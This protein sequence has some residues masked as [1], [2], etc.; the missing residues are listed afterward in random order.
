MPL[1]TFYNEETY[2]QQ[3]IKKV[4]SKENTLIFS[5]TLL[6]LS[7]PRGVYLRVL[8]DI[9]LIFF[10]YFSWCI[11][12]RINSVFLFSF[13]KTF[14][15]LLFV[16]KGTYCRFERR[17]RGRKVVSSA[18][19]FRRFYTAFCI[20]VYVSC[21]TLTT[22]WTNLIL[23]MLSVFVMKKVTDNISFLVIRWF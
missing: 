1:A 20:T 4:F 18:A 9:I 7:S 13:S 5:P 17:N 15:S 16:S 14:L 8:R 21:H 10:V 3:I 22:P 19:S 11:K 2:S 12:S 6:R 23:N